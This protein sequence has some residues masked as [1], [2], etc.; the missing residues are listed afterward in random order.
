LNV[1]GNENGSLITST[2][3]KKQICVCGPKNIAV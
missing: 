1:Q 3:K 2:N